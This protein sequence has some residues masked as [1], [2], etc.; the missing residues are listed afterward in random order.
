MAEGKA[1]QARLRVIG[2]ILIAPIMKPVGP[3]KPLVL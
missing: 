2:A 1:L 3:P